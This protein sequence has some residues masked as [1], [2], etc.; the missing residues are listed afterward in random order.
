MNAHAL[1]QLTV[2]VNHG[3]ERIT[4]KIA[5]AAAAAAE[6]RNREQKKNI[7]NKF[8]K[9]KKKIKIY[10]KVCAKN[11]YEQKENCNK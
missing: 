9:K 5:A 4:G 6:N 10:I 11:N 7:P 3:D 2:S 1:R 8:Q